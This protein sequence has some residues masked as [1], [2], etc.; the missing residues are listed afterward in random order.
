M[1]LFICSYS[2]FSLVNEKGDIKITNTPMNVCN[3]CIKMRC[4]LGIW[5]TKRRD[6]QFEIF[7]LSVCVYLNLIGLHKVHILSICE[8]A[9]TGQDPICKKYI[10][11]MLYFNDWIVFAGT[12]DFYNPRMACSDLN[13]FA[14]IKTHFH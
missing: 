5:L 8:F 11:K 14:E 10:C 13:Y 7:S 1:I 12:F 4:F 2:G 9:D 3:F 6:K